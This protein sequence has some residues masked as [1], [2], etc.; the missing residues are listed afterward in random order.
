MVLGGGVLLILLIVFIFFKRRNSAKH[1]LYP[2]HFAMEEMKK[3]EFSLCSKPPISSSSVTA[4]AAGGIG[5]GA[6][7]TINAS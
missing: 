7:E 5:E 1:T 2:N 6:G 3:G 4:S